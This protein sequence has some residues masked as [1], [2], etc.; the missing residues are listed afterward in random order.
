MGPHQLSESPGR[1]SDILRLI[2][3]E[4]SLKAAG[5]IVT[6]YGDVV[7]PR[8]GVVWTGNLIE[9][10]AAAGISETLVRTAVS[11][12]VAAGQLSGEREGRAASIDSPR[13]LA[14]NSP[15]PPGYC[16]ARLRRRSGISYN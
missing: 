16:S 5:F 9:T 11:R 6:I 12:L 14:P 13:R 15:L 2:I 8:G 1:A 3:D 10:C 7:E 4:V